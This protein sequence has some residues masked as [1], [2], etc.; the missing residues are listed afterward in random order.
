MNGAPLRSPWCAA[1]LLGLTM[2][3]AP[4]C[5]DEALE[6]APPDAG[7]PP[8]GLTKEQASTVPGRRHHHHPR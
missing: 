3:A 2:I 7:P 4:G 8:G 5:D 1:L 6:P